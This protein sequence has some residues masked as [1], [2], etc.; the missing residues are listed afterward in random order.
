LGTSE[1]EGFF[2]MKARRARIVLRSISSIKQEWTASLTGKSQKVKKFDE[3]TIVVTGLET[4]AKIFSKS[5][6]EILRAI[7]TQKPKSIYELAKILDRDFKN[8]YSDVQF[9]NDIGL[10]KLKDTTSTRKGLMPVARFSGVE[11]D[12]VA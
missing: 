4:V 9:L 1:E 2:D 8:V 10:I 12:L 7:I 3:S 6:M 11:F 5:R